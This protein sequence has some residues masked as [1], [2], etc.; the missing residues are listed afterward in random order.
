MK[1]AVLL[2]TLVMAATAQLLQAADMILANGRIYTVNAAQPW[3]QA[4]VIQDGVIE[5]VGSDEQAKDYLHMETEWVDLEGRLVL[6]GFIDVHMHP[7]VVYASLDN[8]CYLKG[9]HSINNHLNRL[10]DCVHYQKGQDWFLGWGHWE[11][12]VMDSET[13]PRVLL[14]E[15]VGDKP[16]VILSRSGHSSWVNTTALELL[17]W[18]SNTPNPRGGIIFRQTRGGEPNGL[19]F[20]TASDIVRELIYAPST[21]AL[22]HAYHGYLEAMEEIP[23]YGLTTIADARVFWTRK[24]HEVWQKIEQED[25]L[26]TRMILHLWAYP[27]KDDSQIGI[28]KS[29]YSNEPGS[30]LRIN[31]IKIYADGLIDNTTAAMKSPYAIDYGIIQGNAGLNYFDQKRMTRFITE[32]EKTGFNF[33]I[34]AIGDRGVHESLNAIESAI[35]TNGVAHDRRHRITHV[36]LIDDVDLQR[37]KELGVIADFQ[38]AAEWT[39]PLEYKPYA[40]DFIDRRINYVYRIRDLFDDGATVT[41]S[42]DF[43]VSDMNP[44]LG[45]ENSISRGEQSLPSLEAAIQAYTLNAAYALALEDVTGSIEPGKSADLIVL[46]ENIF[47][48]PVSQISRAKVL[49]TLLEGRE[50]YGDAAW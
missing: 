29:L 22:E 7:S 1:S 35:N 21:R 47:E 6:P 46:D 9:G 8:F 12:D 30:L 41:L 31:G 50:T 2:V 14:D 10:K 44:L 19:L 15:T 11:A 23:A 26:K 45:I 49:W 38:L 33:M 3:A 5:F 43:D 20:D 36:D 25:A 24:H 18:D 13:P 39:D 34:H 40:Y 42:S 32:L 17:G 16:A 37:F 27:Q 4:L 48:M 28:L